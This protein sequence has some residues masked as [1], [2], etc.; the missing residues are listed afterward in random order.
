[1]LCVLITFTLL[2][3]HANIVLITFSIKL[4]PLCIVSLL[5]QKYLN[6][7]LPNF[8]VENEVDVG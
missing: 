1:M 5:Y 8:V 2:Y 6:V 3:V 7:V 4:V